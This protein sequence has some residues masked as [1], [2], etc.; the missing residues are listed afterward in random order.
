MTLTLFKITFPY[1]SRLV[2]A[3]NETSALHK[4]FGHSYKSFYTDDIT[5]EVLSSVESYRSKPR[6]SKL[7]ALL[8]RLM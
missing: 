7:L 2:L 6:A 8:R 4:A 1:G 3:E 5:I